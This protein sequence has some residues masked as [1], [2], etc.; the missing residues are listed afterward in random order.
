MRTIIGW[1]LL[2]GLVMVGGLILATAW[3]ATHPVE[4][5]R[6]CKAARARQWSKIA[7]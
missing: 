1:A 5:D 7:N 3:I 2:A 4:C 6:A